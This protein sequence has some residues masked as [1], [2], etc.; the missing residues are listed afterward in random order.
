MADDRIE[1]ITRRFRHFVAGQGWS[2]CDEKAI[3]H[4]YQCTVTDGQARVPVALYA[5][6]KTL[7]QGKASALQTALKAWDQPRPTQNTLLP[8]TESSPLTVPHT[9]IP[10]ATGVARIGSDESG[11]GDFY[12]P[13][14][15][16]AVFVDEHNESQLLRLGVRDSKK[17]TDK[18]IS[19]LAR[20]IQ[21][22]CQHKILTYAPV[23][24][25]QLYQR[26]S[27][28]NR[29]LAGAHA[30][31]ITELS[32]NVPAR[33]AIVD[34]FGDES[35]V[36]LEL[37]KAASPLRLEQ[38][39]RAEDDTAV[40]AASILARAKFVRDLDTLSEEIG[41]QLP[42]GASNPQI[43]TIGRQI[44]A[45]RGKDA[46]SSIAKLHFKTAATILQTAPEDEA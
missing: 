1:E 28:L 45:R 33:L 40:A 29:L 20:E 30:R 43:V 34:Q 35:L 21:K 6:G 18:N 42:K 37:Q 41:V 25:N 31:V 46:L 39:H 7:V 8:A 19:A 38:R 15:I 12:G 26:M 27:N 14:V 32:K 16:A 3:A 24:Y 4:G 5:T 13:L 44:V 36:R 9:A 2:I 11:K 22:L 10:Q 17:L 23:V